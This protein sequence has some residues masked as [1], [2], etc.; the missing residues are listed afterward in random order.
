MPINRYTA[1][2]SILGNTYGGDGK[3]TFALPNLCGQ[4]IVNSGQGP[5]L[6]DYRLGQMTGSENETLLP[7]EL[8][9]H[10]HALSGTFL[11]Q[12]GEGTSNDPTSNFPATTTEP[13]YSE[14][15]GTGTMGPSMLKG[16]GWAVG[17]NQPHTNQMPY[18]A[19]NYIICLS[20]IFPPRP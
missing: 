5:G 2:F 19:I 12:V 10:V 9:P 13:Q 1:L 20:G 15:A 14:S 8:P 4:A 11:T 17:D 3:S 6:T 16:M 7:T 18:L